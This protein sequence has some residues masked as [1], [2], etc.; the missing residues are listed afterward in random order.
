MN[1]LKTIVI[2]IIVLYLAALIS[3]SLLTST[4]LAS[5]FSSNGIALIKIDG[6]IVSNGGSGLFSSGNVDSDTV[7]AQINQAEKAS[8]VKAIIFEI[9]SGGGAVVASKEIADKIKTVEKPTIALIREV[10]ASGAYWAASS[11][12]YVIADE[13]SITGSIGVIA[14]YLEFSGLMEKY[15]VEYEGLTTGKYKDT[16]TPY[17]DLTPEERALLIKKLEIIEERFIQDIAK[18]RNLEAEKVRSLA[19]GMFFL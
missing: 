14:S 7:I 18:N 19:T 3:S 16:G 1:K 12:D 15:G 9:N 11:T 13:L 17:R 5:E 4:P 10:G 2:V 6:T 8:G